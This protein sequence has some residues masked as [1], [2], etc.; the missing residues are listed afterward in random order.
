MKTT[1]VTEKF[2]MDGREVGYERKEGLENPELYVH[3]LINTIP[4]GV[5][6]HGDR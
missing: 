1:N 3:P 2:T 5:D 6:N 4:H